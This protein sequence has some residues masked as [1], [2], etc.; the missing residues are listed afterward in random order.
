MVDAGVAYRSKR[1][2]AFSARF[3]GSKKI[4]DRFP[5]FACCESITCAQ[6]FEDRRLTR[7]TKIWLLRFIK[8]TCGDLM[9]NSDL[10]RTIGSGNRWRADAPNDAVW[11]LLSSL[12]SW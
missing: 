7:Y 9:L 4:S 5:Q 2:H 3:T 1:H 8:K 6:A 12:R 11:N 10:A